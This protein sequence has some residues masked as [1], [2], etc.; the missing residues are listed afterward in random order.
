MVRLCSTVSAVF[1]CVFGG[2]LCS[3]FGGP[4]CSAV[5]SGVFF[6]SVYPARLV[7]VPSLRISALVQGRI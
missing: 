7:Y 5:F 6:L 3:V 1:D 4:L 2:P